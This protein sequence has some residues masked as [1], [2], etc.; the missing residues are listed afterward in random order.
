MDNKGK[1]KLGH[2]GAILM[3][4]VMTVAVTYVF[5][6]YQ[7][8]DYYNARFGDLHALELKYSKLKEISDVVDKNFIAE[9]DYADAMDGAMAGFIDGLGDKWSGYYTAEQTKAIQEANENAYVGIGVTLSTESETPFLI[10]KVAESSPA[11][12]AGLLPLDT[13]T[14][15]DGVPLEEIGSQEDLVNT[16]RGA[17][18]SKVNLTVDRMGE[19]L[20]FEMKRAPV[21]YEGVEAYML[22]EQVG[23]IYISGFETHVDKEFLQKLDMLL[24]EGARAFIFD[25][26]MNGGGK[27]DVMSNM[28]DKLL[29]EG[30]IISLVDN[31]G[32]TWPTMSDS[33]A[34]EM[35]MAVL[36]NEYSISAAEFF[37]AALQEYGVARVVGMPTG[38]KGY[39]QQTFTLSDGSSVNLSVL[40]YYTPK[41]NSLIDTGILPEVEVDLTD[42]DFINFYSLADEDDT[43]L[44][45]ALSYVLGELPE[46]PAG[47]GEEGADTDGEPTSAAAGG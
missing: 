42:E 3:L 31:R 46:L 10:V 22:P 39:A 32:N 30:I 6:F 47:D 37:A 23:Y 34:L 18:G 28:L 11:S 29:P 25:V 13:I 21:Y 35:P 45:A 41:G 20:T 40:R 7:A 14:H 36:I 38:G 16:V 44:Q 43:Q 4:I 17:E 2:L 19:S 26:R 5:C 33:E 15:V 27:V 9:Y 24:E 12:E 1:I 8:R